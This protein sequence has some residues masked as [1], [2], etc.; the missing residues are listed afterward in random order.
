MIFCYISFTKYYLSDVYQMVSRNLFASG[1]AALLRLLDGTRRTG[2]IYERYL[3]IS[4]SRT[5]HKI[6]SVSSWHTECISSLYTLILYSVHLWRLLNTRRLAFSTFRRNI[7]KIKL[8]II[9]H[10]LFSIGKTKH[11]MNFKIKH[12]YIT[13]E[14][15]LYS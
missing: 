13:N 4:T 3:F 10:Y 14:N 5:Y 1:A 7:N 11:N 12:I 9:L 8:H 2:N 6:I 15:T